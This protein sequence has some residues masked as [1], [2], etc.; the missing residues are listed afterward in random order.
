MV[1]QWD[2][3]EGRYVAVD[4]ADLEYALADG[5]PGGIDLEALAMEEELREPIGHAATSACASSGM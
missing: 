2:H 1:L 3:S 5:V 4:S